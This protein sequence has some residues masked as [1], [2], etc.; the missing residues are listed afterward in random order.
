M[1]Y[2]TQQGDKWKLN[3]DIRKMVKFEYFNLLDPM[4]RLGQFDII[5]CRNVLIYF[6]EKTK[7]KVLE[8][9]ARQIETDGY[10]FL[11][12]AETVLGITNSFKPIT[13]QRG[14]YAIEKSP[15]VAPAK[16]AGTATG[17][18]ALA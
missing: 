10:L 15:H 18:T 3:D 1:K 4:I 7:A 8:N 17:T 13:A 12:G 2:F 11:G 9:M 14:L 6:D 16:P 5:F